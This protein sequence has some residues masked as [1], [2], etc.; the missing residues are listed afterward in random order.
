MKSILLIKDIFEE[1][2]VEDNLIVS[3]RQAYIMYL[4]S[5]LWILNTLYG[6]YKLHYINIMA[7]FLVS[8]TSLLYWKKPKY[9]WR[10]NIDI[11]AC[12][13]SSAYVTYIMYSSEYWILYLI[14]KKLGLLSYAIG[15]YYH[16]KNR[17]GMGL[18]C[19][20]LVHVSAHI[21]CIIMFNLDP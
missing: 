14:I 18:F 1:N 16:N 7:P 9:D 11:L 12:V 4:Y 10:R 19:H 15:H 13:M 6:L 21:S 17:L 5:H 2:I 8:C 3:K 20:M